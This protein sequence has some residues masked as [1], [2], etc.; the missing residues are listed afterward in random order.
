LQIAPAVLA[1]LYVVVDLNAAFRTK[2]ISS[3]FAGA[4]FR[5]LETA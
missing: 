1:K 3:S 2:H 4:F 5:F